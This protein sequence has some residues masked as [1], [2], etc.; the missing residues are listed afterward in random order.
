[1]KV[2]NISKLDAEWNRVCTKIM[3]DYVRVPVPRAFLPM[4]T[5]FF[6]HVSDAMAGDDRPD[7]GLAKMREGREHY[8][9]PFYFIYGKLRRAEKRMS[10]SV[11]R[12]SLELFQ[13]YLELS[14]NREARLCE[15]LVRASPNPPRAPTVPA[16]RGRRAEATRRL[17]SLPSKVCTSPESRKLRRKLTGQKRTN[18]KQRWH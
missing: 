5:L 13:R 12:K 17:Q 7:H 9:I 10:R 18:L 15:K 16:A 6:H 11:L 2:R 3:S 4:L 14:E 1:M 8:R